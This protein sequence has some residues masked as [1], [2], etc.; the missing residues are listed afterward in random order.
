MNYKLYT[1]VDITHTGQYR[2]EP[3]KEAARWK[4]Q[5]FN[6]IIQTLGIR[7]NISYSNNPTLLEVKGKLIGFNTNDVIRVWRFDFFTEQDAVYQKD[8]DPVG[9]LK[10]DFN[11]V[12]YINGLDELLEQN[13]A[14]FVTEGNTK[15]IV[16]HQNTINIPITV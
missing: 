4:E 8:N 9:L 13:F 2:S 3:G 16:F 1:L 10:D 15:N 11:L 14:V 6:T 12:P 7:S 5:N